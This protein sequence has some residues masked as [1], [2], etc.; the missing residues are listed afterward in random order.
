MSVGGSPLYEQVLT[1][2]S[3]DETTH[4]PVFAGHCSVVRM[5][6]VGSSG[7]ASGVVT[8]EASPD[9]AFTGTWLPVGGAVS[10]LPD[11]VVVTALGINAAYPYVRARISTVIGS[12][13]VDVVIVGN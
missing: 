2:Q 5:L 1:A 11:T 9:K 8:F 12:G 4:T 3:V 7:V 6:V 13:T 10:A